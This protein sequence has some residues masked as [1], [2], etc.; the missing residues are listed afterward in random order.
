MSSS[1]LPL[2]CDSLIRAIICSQTHAQKASVQMYLV[3]FFFQVAPL[4]L[5]PRLLR[6]SLL[7]NPTEIRSGMPSIAASHCDPR[8]GGG[9]DDTAVV[10]SCAI[11]GVRCCGN[12]DDGGDE[13]AD[14]LIVA[15]AAPRILQA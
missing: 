1:V 2:F 13:E 12:G 11:A 5:V 9:G 15:T 4:P 8:S 10:E 7:T 6:S 3:S 14:C